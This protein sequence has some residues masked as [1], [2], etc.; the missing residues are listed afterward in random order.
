LTV[1]A[2]TITVTN[3]TFSG[4]TATNGGGLSTNGSTVATLRGLTIASNTAT[5]KGGGIY[6]P[7]G[8]ISLGSSI[9][10][11]NTSPDGP[12]VRLDGGAMTTAGYNLIGIN[13]T[14]TATFPAGNP[15]ASNDIVGTAASPISANLGPLADNGGTR[16]VPTRS[17]LGGS[18][19]LDKGSSFGSTT[20]ERGLPRPVDAASIPNATGGDGADI[21]AF[22]VQAS[23]AG[24]VTVSGA[25][26]TADGYGVAKATVTITDG[27]GNARTVRSSSFGYFRFDDLAVGDNYILTVASKQ[28]TFAPRVVFLTDELAGFDMVAES[29]TTLRSIIKG[30]Q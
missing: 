29:T 12:D 21:G 28:Y 3:T 27:F 30:D 7:L 6:D 13:T 9:V 16:R 19:A 2:T 14:A 23:T 4:N 22:E 10:A 5:S 25:V 20:D 17:P 11:G 18:P 1:D 26:R 15:N 8:T 24:G